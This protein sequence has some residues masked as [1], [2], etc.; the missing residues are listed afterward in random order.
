MTNIKQPISSPLE[1][2]P[3]FS[4]KLALLIGITHGGALIGIWFAALGFEIK[5]SLIIWLL[6]VTYYNINKYL[7][8]KHQHLT[9]IDY[10]IV[11]PNDLTAVILPHVYVHSMFVILPLKLSNKTFE[12]FILFDDSLD[13]ATFHY[14][15]VRLLHPLEK[16]P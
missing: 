4:K 11:L 5:V 3:R 9:L 8:L 15:R 13:E 6:I 16:K 7:F 14:L 12:T 10:Y 1:I 2:K